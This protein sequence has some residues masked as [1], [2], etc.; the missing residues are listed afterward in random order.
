MVGLWRSQILP[1]STAAPQEQRQGWGAATCK[2]A[3][4]QVGGMAM[5]RSLLGWKSDI[6]AV[7]AP[8]PTLGWVCGKEDPWP[9]CC[10]RAG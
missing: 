3:L 6:H 1:D 9:Q 8:A 7:P 4:V 2:L 10:A 5:A